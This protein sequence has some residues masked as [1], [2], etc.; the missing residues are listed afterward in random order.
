MPIDKPSA[1]SPTVTAFRVSLPAF[2]A[3][4]LYGQ[5]GGLVGA[6]SLNPNPALPTLADVTAPDGTLEHDPQ[7]LFVLGLQDIQAGKTLAAATEAGWRFFAGNAPGKVVVG[8]ASLRPPNTAWKLTNVTVGPG[9]FSSLQQSHGLNA[10]PQVKDNLYDLRFLKI[11]GIN[12]EAFWL[13]SRSDAPALLVPSPAGADQLQEPLANQPIYTEP[14]FLNI[15]QTLT[16]KR[17][18]YPPQ[19]GS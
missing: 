19:Y 13:F 9:V 1:P 6:A 12:V 7:Q 3:G 15:V 18:D 14:D 2:L 11:P 17:I 10:L 8:Y 16:A 4:P 5:A